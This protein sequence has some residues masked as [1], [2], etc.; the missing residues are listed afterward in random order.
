MAWPARSVAVAAAVSARD[1]S[2][3]RSSRTASAASAAASDAAPMVSSRMSDR[4]TMASATCRDRARPSAAPCCSSRISA[5][6]RSMGAWR[7][8]R[9][10]TD[11]GT[12]ME[13]ESTSAP[14]WR[15]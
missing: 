2:P 12:C 5:V 9:P 10:S 1:T 8:Q 13:K 6:D 3:P 7:S 11:T 14:S 4:V 15:P